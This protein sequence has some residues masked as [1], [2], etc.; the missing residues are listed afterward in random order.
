MRQIFILVIK[1]YQRLLSPQTG[2]L[3]FLYLSPMITLS[4]GV[5]QGCRFYPTCSEYTKKALEYYP[6]PKALRLSFKRITKC[7]GFNEGGVDNA[8]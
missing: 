3:K 7:H 2:L 5:Y 1:I 4:G 8:R 6:L